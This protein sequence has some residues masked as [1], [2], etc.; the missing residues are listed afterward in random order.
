MKLREGDWLALLT[1]LICVAL[2]VASYNALNPDGV[3]YLDLATRL[4]V[5][6]WSHFVQGYWSPLY[7]ALVAVGAVL[8][9]RS[10]PG[11]IGVVHVVNTAIALFGV[12]VIWW[13]ARRSGSV[14]FARGAFAAFLVC[15]A[16]AP[17]LEAV[18]PD[19]LLVAFVALIGGELLLYGGRRPARLGLWMGLAF[20]TKTS[21]WPWMVAS[22]LAW[23]LLHRNRIALVTVGKAAAVCAIVMSLW[24]VPMSIKQGAPTLGSAARLNA[25]W[26]IR[27]CDSRSPDT[28]REEHQAYHPF[29]AGSSHGRIALFEGTPWTYLPWSDPTA[30]A[31]GLLSAS[32]GT[33]TLQQHVVYTAKQLALVVGIWMPH[34]WFAIL[35]PIGWLMRRRGMWGELVRG[36]GDAGLVVALGALGILQF[37]AVHVEPRLVAPFTLLLALGALGWLTGVAGGPE[38][39]RPVPKAT[40]RLTLLLSGIGLLLALPR[41]ALHAAGQWETATQVASRTAMIE[42][43]D[44]SREILRRGR[45]RIAVLGEVFPLL[46]EAYRLG[47]QIEW[48][49]FD[50]PSTTI[51]AW[52]PEDQQALIRWLASQGATEAWLSKPGGTFS[53]LPL[54]PQ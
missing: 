7:P 40:S 15:S 13:V 23:A 6:D 12:A 31:S 46:T 30:W 16:E 28:H 2:S 44:A 24:V 50:P 48:Q 36:R 5:G 42:S 32:K 51:M 8:S 38:V 34:I 9:G 47:G 25:C 20:L 14:I 35:L 19:L 11:L 39:E 22:L 53:L 26:Y 17:R 18:T 27:E 1:A 52:P 21:M 45:R 4:G 49:V 37:V 43:S 29:D 33:P 3:S 41:A 54:P 10:G